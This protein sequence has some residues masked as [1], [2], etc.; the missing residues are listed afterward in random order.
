MQNS[1]LNE[2]SAKLKKDLGNK[3]Y[4]IPDFSNLSLNDIS[5]LKLINGLEKELYTQGPKKDMIKLLE[6]FRN[7]E[8]GTLKPFIQIPYKYMLEKSQIQSVNGKPKHIMIL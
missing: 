8:E 4:C 7:N 6:K 3:V 1:L 5:G 2:F